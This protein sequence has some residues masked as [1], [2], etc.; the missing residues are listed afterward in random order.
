[1]ARARLAADKKGARRSGRVIAFLDETGFTFRARVATTW[2]PV[3]H[4]PVL[5]RLSKRREVS[6]VVA[7]TT[8]LDGMP[9]QLY[10][11]HFLKAIQAPEVIT[12][13]RYFRARIGRP[14]IIV[15]DHLT[16]HRAKRVAAFVR[17]HPEDF[18]IEWL[19]GYAPELNPEEPCNNAVKLAMFNATPASVDELR[20]MARANFIRLGRKAH[21]LHH[22]FRYAGLSVN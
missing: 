9:P 22:F 18:I 4:P 6:S 13:L 19:P 14:L 12:A 8:P 15:W 1:M 20:A 17:C 10:A 11:R 2:A 3:G 16:A 5:R 21:L 7:M